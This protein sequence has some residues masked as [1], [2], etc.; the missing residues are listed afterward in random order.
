MKK[1]FLAFITAGAF[2]VGTSLFISCGGNKD[3]D[4][5]HEDGEMHEHMESE[6]HHHDKGKMSN[7]EHMNSDEQVYTCP[8]H[9]EITGKEGD[10]CSECEMD[11]VME[12][13]EH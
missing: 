13:D 9:P 2:V 7:T 1:T 6:E 3:A 12:D 8:M 10:K 11:L 4:H 5:N